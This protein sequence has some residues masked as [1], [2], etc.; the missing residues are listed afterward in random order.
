MLFCYW[1]QVSEMRSS[2]ISKKVMYAFWSFASVRSG[3]AGNSALIYWSSFWTGDA[4]YWPRRTSRRDGSLL[5]APADFLGGEC[6]PEPK[7][8]RPFDEVVRSPIW[9]FEPE[10]P[11]YPLDPL[12]LSEPGCLSLDFLSCLFL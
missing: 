11:I 8:P 5:S 9:P 10:V 12:L 1:R 2:W 3:R 7:A 6:D 4:D